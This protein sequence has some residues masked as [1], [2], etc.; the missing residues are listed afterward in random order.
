MSRGTQERS[1]VRKYDHSSYRK[2]HHSRL[3]CGR[4]TRNPFLNFLR[5]IRKNA[6]GLSITEVA[7]KGAEIWRKMDDRQKQPY[8]Q[9]AKEARKMAGR[10][11]H[12]KRRSKRRSNSRRKSRTRS[13]S[14]KSKSRRKS[15]SRF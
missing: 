13:R 2:K 9:L 3:R 11:K 4:I 6:K 14:R 8:L 1:P 7:S 10:S 15:R 12:S 5:D